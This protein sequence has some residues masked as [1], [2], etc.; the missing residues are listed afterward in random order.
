M[1][2]E[3][4]EQVWS[5]VCGQVKSYNNIDPSQIN[6]FFSRL[7]PQAMSDGF[8][9]ITADNDFIKTWIERHYVE[10]IKR[11]LNDLYHMPFTVIIEVDITA[12]EPPAPA[13]AP[14]AAQA[15]PAATMATA[16]ETPA[17]VSSPQ[18][19]PAPAANAASSPQIDAGR[20][21]AHRGAVGEEVAG[22]GAKREIALDGPD[23]PAST[24]TFENFVIGDSNRMAYSMAVAV[25]E[26]PGK[27]H[28]N[29]LFIYGKSGLG[30]THL[31]RAIQNYINETMPQLSTIYVDSAELLSDYMEASAA[32]DKQKSSYKNFKTRYEEACLPSRSE[33]FST[34]LL[35]AAA[36]KA[37][38]IVTNV[39]GVQE[40]VPSNEHGIILPSADGETIANAILELNSDRTRCLIMGQNINQLV[41]DKFSWSETARLTALAC[42]EAQERR[43]QP[44]L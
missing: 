33:G 27:A 30:K 7:H 4:L 17:P 16:A 1:N 11:A 25:A 37:T 12:A 40:L 41:I 2:S 10:F 13:P 39:G 32:H 9:M 21:E 34:S 31:M 14:P 19:A 35:E 36:C 20:P 6:A 26:M 15:A 38:P 43:N 29:P 22:V 42:A 18:P 5:E 3:K 24:L 23:S 28:L 44:I 8:L